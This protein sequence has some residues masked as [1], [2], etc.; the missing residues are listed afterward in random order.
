[1]NPKS[2]VLI[3]DDEEPIRKLL[4]ARFEREGYAIATAENAEQALQV[5]EGGFRA[6][7]VVTDIKMPGKSGLDLTQKVKALYPKV[8]VI[9]MT[10]H[11]EKST[12]IEALKFG[13]IDYKEKPF[14]LDEMVHSVERVTRELAM[15]NVIPIR[16]ITPPVT[17]EHEV[18]TRQPTFTEVKKKFALQFEQDYLN[19]IL[20]RHQ[21]NVSAAAKES[22]LDRSNFLRLLRRHQMQAQNYRTQVAKKAA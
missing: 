16:P 11:G 3:V 10:G 13:A 14:D 8:Q 9:V 20:T 22:G 18:V 15:Q 17:F 21:G 4:K 2:L 6:E 5:L 7:V 12:A 1:M 19:D